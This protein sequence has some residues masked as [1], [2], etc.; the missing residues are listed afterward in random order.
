MNK[1][2]RPL[3]DKHVRV[4]KRLIPVYGMQTLWA[5][6]G[7]DSTYRPYAPHEA[8][9]DASH[10]IALKKSLKD[11]ANPAATIVTRVRL[12]KSRVRGCIE[13]WFLITKDGATKSYSYYTSWRKRK[14]E[15]S[16]DKYKF[17]RQNEV[18][19]V[20]KEDP[21]PNLPHYPVPICDIMNGE[22][23]DDE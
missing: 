5:I 14:P 3:S 21:L 1:K 20:V 16:E 15:Y 19:W 11:L 9:D 13:D 22:E 2:E 23:D 18:L 6:E 8:Y 12:K 4:L 7:H 10:V 17:L